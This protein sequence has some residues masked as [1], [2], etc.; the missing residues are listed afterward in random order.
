MLGTKNR[1]TDGTR[2]T[3]W[4]EALQS[5]L[6]CGPMALPFGR[7]PVGPLGAPGGG[8]SFPP[9]CVAPGPG[10]LKG[11]T[12][13]RRE[14]RS[15]WP[16]VRAGGRAA[17]S[18]PPLRMSHTHPPASVCSTRIQN[19]ILRNKTIKLLEENTGVTVHDLEFGQGFSDTTPEA[20]ATKEKQNF[21]K[22]KA[23]CIKGHHQES[24]EQPRG[25]RKY[26]QTTY[27]M[28]V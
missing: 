19:L 7:A 2:Q 18:D 9:P 21:T 24:K 10:R 13:L 25:W 20:Q 14:R 26:L 22:T 28:R 23:L 1:P 4:E 6:C 8:L 11:P 17:P 15:H 12:A 3:C 5:P 16:E 27:L